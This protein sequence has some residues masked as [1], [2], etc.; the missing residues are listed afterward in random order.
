MTST[1][2]C[3]HSTLSFA[4]SAHSNE[5]GYSRPTAL[6]RLAAATVKKLPETS[7]EGIVDNDI[8]FSSFPAPLILPLDDLSLDPRYPP[9][10]LRAWT[11]SKDRNKVTPLKNIIYVA[12]PPDI[13]PE[14]ESVRAWSHPSSQNQEKIPCPDTGDIIAYLGAFYDGMSVKPLPVSLSFVAWDAPKRVP[15][16]KRQK[17]L[18]E[19]IGLSTSTECV[20]IRT[21][22][23]ADKIFT[24]Q[25]NLDDLLD[26]AISMLPEDAYALLMLVHHDLYESEDDVFVCGR[27][28]GGSRVAVVSTSR[29]NPVLDCIQ[30]IDRRHSWPASH[31]ESYIKD[32]TSPPQSSIPNHRPKKFP[33]ANL[34][35]DHSSTSSLIGI[36]DRGTEQVAV[37]AMQTAV[38]TVKALPSL[39][40]SPS[41]AALTGLWLGRICRT[42]SH[43]LGHCFGMD[44]CVYYACVM[45]GSASLLEDER[46]PPYLCPVDQAK[47]LTATGSSVVQHYNALLNFCE[48]H[49]E[50]HLFSAF[51]AWI[52]VRLEILTSKRE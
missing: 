52:R 48:S 28:Y 14:V 1:R 26:A 6:Q 29:Y 19:Y 45:Q 16:R 34:N 42:T 38:N 27:A 20:R 3:H 49:S 37:S 43:E 18:L 11:R 31:C 44:H 35:P 36:P 50:S 2:H 40:T 17:S 46:Q 33:K 32:I 4:S 23:S 25:L 9:Q 12:A 10:S 8:D 5:A 39:C 22:P 51:A 21:R 30:D 7:T 15:S 24:R 47:L 41:P 13:D